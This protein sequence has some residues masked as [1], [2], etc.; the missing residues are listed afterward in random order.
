MDPRRLLIFRTVVRNGSIGAGARELGW[1]Q[2]AVSQHLAALEKEVGTQLLLRSSSGVTP[3]EA[4]HRLSIHAE[5]I[6]AQLHAAEEELADIT[7]LRRGRVRF[8]TFPSAAAVFLP[9][10]LARMSEVAPKVEVSFAELEPPDAIPALLDNEL[11]LAM[12]FRYGCTDIDAEGTLEWTPLLE[13]RVLAI[14]PREHPRA[15]DPELTL[16]D[17]AKENWIAGCERCRA[18]LVARAREAGFTPRIRHST[19][20]AT[21]VQR[22]ITHG[23][24]VALLPDITL[25]ASPSDQVVVRALPELVPRT[26]GLI[27]RRGALSIPAVAA[28]RDALVAETSE[29]AVEAALI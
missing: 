6:A 18:N 12:V 29:R 5:S 7:A 28:L 8:A 19:D 2:P 3:T 13:D 24:G 14:L 25:E 26:I 4:G 17:L 20:D 16:A 23:A 15:E 22:L 9:P 27:N 21:V 10:A 11:D 1:T